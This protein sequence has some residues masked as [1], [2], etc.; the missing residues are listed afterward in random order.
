[1]LTRFTDFDIH[2]F[3]EGKHHQLY[4]KL[5]SHLMETEDGVKGTYFAVWAPNAKNVSVIGDFNGWDKTRNSLQLRLDGTGIWEGFVP[6]A[7]HGNRYK[8]AITSRIGGRQLEKSDLFARRWE[9]PPNTATVIWDTTYEW[10]DAAWMTTRA[11]KAQ[12]PQPFSVYEVHLGSWRRKSGR[13]DDW[14]SYRELAVELVAYVQKMGFT[15]VEFLPVTE[16]PFYGSWGYQAIGYFAP[17]SR[18]G[19]PQDF[20]YL[21][22]AFHKAGIGVIMDWVPSH[23]PADA[24]ALADYDGTHLYDHADPRLG[25]HPDWNSCIFNYGRNEVRSFLVSS[26]MFWLEHYHIDGIRVDAV[27]SML[28]LD[29]SRKS[30][31]WIPNKFGGNENLEAIQF[32]RELNEAAAKAFPDVM[33]IAEESTAWPKV[34]RPIAAGGLGFDQK[35]MMGWMHDTLEYFKKDPL[36]RKYHHNEIS[37]SMTYV[38]NENF[39]LPLSH[40][41]VVHGKGALL[42]RMSGDDWKRFA[43]LRLLYGFMFTHPGTQLLFMGCEFGQLEEWRHDYSLDWHLLEHS[44]HRDVQSWVIALNAYYKNTPALYHFG[45]QP[46]GFEWIDYQDNANC[47]LAYVRKGT[48]VHQPQLIICNFTPN[49]AAHYRIGVPQAGVYREVLNSDD[50]RWGGSGVLNAQPIHSEPIGWHYREHSIEVTL[51]PFGVMCFGVCDA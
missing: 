45:F 35:W 39:M 16:H 8:Y 7:Q 27:A 6:S 32:I 17:T 11:E 5:G 50:K 18:Y 51:S 26:A 12:Q 33:M 46:K 31:E 29:Y 1:M 22:E 49:V 13:R 43:Q 38:Y 44:F 36:Y 15:H 19:S 34:S 41:E 10:S 3:K 9:T 40:D 25:F 20:K 28:Y 47:V 24:H 21:V 4:D 14:L 30:D 37:Q 2:L 42:A 48:A 23:F